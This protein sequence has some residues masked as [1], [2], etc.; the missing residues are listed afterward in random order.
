MQPFVTPRALETD[1]IPGIVEAYRQGAENARL[2][3]FDGVEI[4]GANGYLLDQFLQD[5]TNHRTDAYGGPIE[6]RARLMLE[7]DRRG[8]LGLG[9]GRVGMHLAPRGDAHAWGIPI[10][11][12]PSATSPANSGKRGIAFLCVRESRSA[13]DRLG[14][15]LKEPSAASTSPTRGSR[16]RRPSRCSRPARPTPSPSA[17]SFIA[18]P[19]LPRRF[20]L[21]RPLN[22]PDPDDLLRLGP[23]R[24]HRLSLALERAGTLTAWTGRIKP[25][26]GDHAI[27]EY[28]QLGGSGFKVPALSFGTGTFGGS[29]EFF[30]A[31]GA[32][33]VAEATRLVDI[34]LDAGLTMFDSADV[35]SDGHGRGDPRAGDQGPPRQGAHL[36]QGDVPHRATGPNDVGSSRHHLIRAVE[37]QPAPARHRLHRPLP[38]ARLRRADAGRGDA[39]ARSTTWCAPARSATSA[40]RTSPAGT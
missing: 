12:R 11:R 26:G 37:A 9:A 13:E 5:S 32:T 39:R 1:E 34:C 10:R 27:M 29:G 35:Y 24:L 31:W 7:V 20:A 33:D 19:D 28:R 8:D 3:G 23:A 21:G 40:A 25:I 18:N 4:H 6:N 2:A 15:E 30:K 16:R 36:D 14:P 22:E 38:A 17:S